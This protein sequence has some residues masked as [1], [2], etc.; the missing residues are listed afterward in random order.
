MTC[1]HTFCQECTD[2]YVQ[3]AMQTG[4]AQAYE[5]C[6]WLLNDEADASFPNGAAFRRIAAKI[7]Q[8]AEARRAEGPEA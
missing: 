1:T 5:E 6:A 4:R 7:R 3:N 2:A 8:R